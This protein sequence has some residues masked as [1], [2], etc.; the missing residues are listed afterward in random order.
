MMPCS[1]SSASSTRGVTV[2]APE[3]SPPP[4]ESLDTIPEAL[5]NL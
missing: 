2:M 4:F 1:S 5:S 3:G